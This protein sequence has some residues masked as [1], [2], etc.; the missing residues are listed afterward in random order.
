MCLLFFL[1]WAQV[2]LQKK[3]EYEKL[4]IYGVY[5]D[6]VCKAVFCT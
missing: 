1:S 6:S 4:S 5:G 2:G 3:L